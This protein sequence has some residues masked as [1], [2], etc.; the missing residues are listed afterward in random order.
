MERPEFNIT[1]TPAGKV[2]VEIKGVK[3]QRCV[4]LAD[5]LK[6]IVGKE[7]Q[8][9][10]TADYYAPDAKVRIDAKVRESTG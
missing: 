9:Q 3:G 2:K 7:E 1:L 6:E 4:D 8:R 5:L 10:L